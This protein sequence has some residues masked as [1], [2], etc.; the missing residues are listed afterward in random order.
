M[1]C[2]PEDA[3]NPVKVALG[4]FLT[5]GL[6]VSFMP[7]HIKMIRLRSS[8]GLSALFVLFAGIAGTST[9]F[10]VW[11]LQSGTLGCCKA[12][13]PAYCFE[14]ILGVI[15]VSVQWMALH[16]V[17]GL[18]IACYPEA[19]KW[20]PLG[21]G[22]SA[23]RRDTIVETGD[24]EVDEHGEA[25]A[26]PPLPIPKLPFSPPLSSTPGGSYVQDSVVTRPSRSFMPP[27]P[28]GSLSDDEA[29]LA[30]DER[31]T[32]LPGRPAAAADPAGGYP[33]SVPRTAPIPVPFLRVPAG[34]SPSHAYLSAISVTALL[35]TYFVL[36]L[37][38]SLLVVFLDPPSGV[39]QGSAAVLYAGILGLISTVFSAVQFLP[40][41]VH[42]WQEGRVGA[43]SVGMLGM[44]APG[45]FLFV[46]SLMLQPGTN[47]S[48]WFPYL[49]SGLAQS[50]LLGL[51]L[52]F[53]Y[54]P[55]RWDEEK[56]A[57][58]LRMYDEAEEDAVVERPQ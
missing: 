35:V 54:G 37:L 26:S 13:S 4:V 28:R 1:E 46:Y 25:P 34:Q 9:L 3:R 12:W 14:N 40:Q 43:L 51:A 27:S 21:G 23:E 8:E 30:A 11:V 58:V 31:T 17:I 10:N 57:R 24:E 32:L 15:Q 55:P 44:Q 38:L 45:S 48:T 47:I 52:W 39:D 2:P 41:I 50:F 18:F 56:R 29:D 36:C 20:I 33:P 5:T 16:L 53:T 22:P 6:V 7:Q 49:L 42:T 19:K